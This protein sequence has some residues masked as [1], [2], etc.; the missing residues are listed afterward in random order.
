MKKISDKERILFISKKQI[1]NRI[2]YH[3]STKKWFI[4]NG[5]GTGSE[6]KSLRRAIDAAMKA[7]RKRKL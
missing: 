3:H 5:D 2:T 6:R 7:E 4:L 1:R